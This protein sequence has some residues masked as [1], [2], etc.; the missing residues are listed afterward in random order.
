M[1][2]GGSGN[3]TTGRNTMQDIG[4][5]TNARM[6]RKKYVNDERNVTVPI[7]SSVLQGEYVV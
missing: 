5:G 1:Q 6:S 3:K 2:D 4:R 7:H